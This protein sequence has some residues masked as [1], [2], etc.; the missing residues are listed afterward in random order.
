M[1]HYEVQKEIGYFEVDG[2]LS[3]LPSALM[4]YL[5]DT[6]IRHSDALGY[7]LD[8]LAEVER[9]WAVL[10]WHVSILRMPQYGE[11]LN[12]Q[13]WSHRCRRMQAERG[14]YLL[15]EQDNKVILAESRWVLMDLKRRR[16]MQIP[17]DMEERYGNSGIMA[18]E[19]ERYAMPKVAEEM[20]T[21]RSFQVT[22]SQTDT[23]RHVNNVK[24]IEWAMDDVPDEIYEKM[25]ITDI[26][27]VYRK[28]CYRGTIVESKCYVRKTEDN[29]TEVLSFFH[30]SEDT[31][32]VYAEV[33]SLW[34]NPDAG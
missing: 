6:A 18:I 1:K 8:Y 10:N 25:K 7:T 21:S 34:R 33:S 3:L 13:T 22:R 4:T 23:N 20:P 19:G 27:V 9:G 16:P 31:S 28:E 32:C 2:F 14:F 11:K 12:I 15:D 26:R 29:L 5:Q 30:D 17:A 24:Y